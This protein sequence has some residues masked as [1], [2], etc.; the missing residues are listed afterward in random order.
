MSYTAPV[1][2]FL[3][4]FK[5]LSDAGV[6]Y[7]TVGGLATVLH[8]YPR[9]TS[10]IDLIVQLDEVN[11]RKALQ[12][13]V[14]LKFRPLA[15]VDPFDFAIRAKREEWIAT[16]GLTVFS[17]H[18]TS[19]LPIEIDIFVREPFAFDDLWGKRIVREVNGTP[20]H[21]IDKNSLITLKQLSGR[22]KDLEDI[23]ALMRLEDE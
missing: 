11:C 5:A 3:P 23:E 21:I 15:P 4:I 8:G 2:I 12:C 18:G 7:L 1:E 14:D 19:G 13:L 10:D 16:K 6:R 9:L 20:I 17:M 22:P